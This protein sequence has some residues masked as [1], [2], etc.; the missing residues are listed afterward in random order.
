MNR[1]H[2]KPFIFFKEIIKQIEIY[3]KLILMMVD[4][5]LYVKVS[6]LN[7]FISRVSESRCFTKIVGGDSFPIWSSQA[8]NINEKSQECLMSGI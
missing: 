6:N 3:E 7:S 5:L 2:N 8:S 1:P 4:T